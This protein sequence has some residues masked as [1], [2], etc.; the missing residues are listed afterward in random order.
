MDRLTPEDINATIEA[1]VR[2]ISINTPIHRDANGNGPKHIGVVYW[3]D[4]VSLDDDVLPPYDHKIT[5]ALTKGNNDA[6]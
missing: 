6:T 2:A 4:S 1:F 5:A 3:E